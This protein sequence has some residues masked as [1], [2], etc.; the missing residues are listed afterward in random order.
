M[1]VSDGIEF[2]RS[3]SG[4][5]RLLALAELSHCVTVVARD[6]YEPDSLNVKDGARLRALNEVQHRMTGLVAQLIGNEESTGADSIVAN[7]FLAEREDKTLRGLLESCF[8]RMSTV[9]SP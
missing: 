9:V 2:L 1:D 6:T 5:K 3:L 7:M 4:E 8:Q